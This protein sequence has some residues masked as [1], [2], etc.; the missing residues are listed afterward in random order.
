MS[1][2]KT[3]LN[4]SYIEFKYITLKIEQIQ[5][6]KLFFIRIYICVLYKDK[7]ELFIYRV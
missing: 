2:I 5:L 3:N 1:C 7:F 6:S 4:Y